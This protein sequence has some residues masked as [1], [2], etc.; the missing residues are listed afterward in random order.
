[1]AHDDSDAAET[2]RVESFFVGQVVTD[3]HRQQRT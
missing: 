2:D 1:V 3:V